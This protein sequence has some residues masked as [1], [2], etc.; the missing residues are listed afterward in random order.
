MMSIKLVGVMSKAFEANWEDRTICTDMLF[1]EASM[2][3]HVELSTALITFTI[4]ARRRR[5]TIRACFML[6]AAIAKT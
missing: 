6:I 5:A 2:V 1:I 3:L 4:S